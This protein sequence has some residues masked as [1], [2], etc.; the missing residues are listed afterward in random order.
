MIL[1]NTLLVHFLV[2]HGISM[3]LNATPTPWGLIVLVE[4]LGVYY[5]QE[6]LGKPIAELSY[7]IFVGVAISELSHL[8]SRLVVIKVS[9]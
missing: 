4:R 8:I 2:E 3:D 5:F 7:M 9:N 6:T 1:F